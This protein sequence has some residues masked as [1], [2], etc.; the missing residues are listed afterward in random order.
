MIYEDASVIVFNDKTEG[1]F[2]P[3]MKP[4]RSGVSVEYFVKEGDTLFSIANLAYGDTRLWFDIAEYN[5][6]NI[7]DIFELEIGQVLYL[8][9]P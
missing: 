9:V 5:F 1:L 4:D 7:E 6:E 2:S 8:P 3:L